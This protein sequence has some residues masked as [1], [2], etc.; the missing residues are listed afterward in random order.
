[1][2]GIFVWLSPWRGGESPPNFIRLQHLHT[3]NQGHY[4]WVWMMWELWFIQAIETL[5][6]ILYTGCSYVVSGSQLDYLVPFSHVGWSFINTVFTPI[7]SHLTVEYVHPTVYLLE[8]T[9]CPLCPDH[10]WIG[11]IARLNFHETKS[12]REV[13]GVKGLR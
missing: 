8:N 12:A 6:T 2:G 13:W 4:K 10:P 1:M 3:W 7:S 11:D 5:T 9:L